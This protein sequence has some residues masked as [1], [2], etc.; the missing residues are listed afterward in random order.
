MPRGVVEPAH[1]GD[2][3]HKAAVRRPVD[4]RAEQHQQARHHHEGGKQRE[5]NG[6]NEAQGHVRA[7]SELHE[8]HGHQTAD[9]GQ[10]AGADLRDGLA[11]G[12]D[13]R[14]PQRQQTVL[15]LEAVAE[16][17]G[18]VDGQRQLQNT[19]D[20]VGHE[21][22]LAHQE[23]GALVQHQ[24]HHERQDQHRHLAVGLGGEQ[25][26]QHDDHGHID[27]DD[28]DL[29][30]DGLPQGVAQ[31]RGYIQIIVAQQLLHRLQRCQ[32]GVV[33]LV[34]GEGDGEQG[35]QGVVVVGGLVV[36]HALHAL[37]LPDLI[38]Q[39]FRLGGGHVGHHQL[40]RAVGDE[41]LVHHRQRLLGLGVVRQVIGQVVLHLHPVPGDGGEDQSDNGDEE[42]ETALV[43]DEGGQLLHKG[44]AVCIALAHGVRISSFLFITDMPLLPAGESGPAGKALF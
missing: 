7:K 26:H 8:Q 40:R 11:Q 37:H 24:R 13:H 4:E 5:Q 35:G 6:F 31:I 27:H 1:K 15:L 42:N 21:G 18:V 19:G 38:G 22:D 43:H 30:V 41:L 34:V 14:L 16:D 17:D 28:A 9:G 33:V 39:L 20:G 32:T 2:L 29:V 36:V 10:A 3:G 25:Q 44:R 23:V 12:H